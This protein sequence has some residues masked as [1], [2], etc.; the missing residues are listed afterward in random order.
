MD[1]D[2]FDRLSRLIAAA[3]TR[4]DALRLVVAGAL[5]GLAGHGSFTEAR[6]RGKARRR[7]RRR[8]QVRTEQ[9]QLCTHLCVD[10]SGK[11]I[12]PGANLSGCDFNDEPFPDRLDLR[13]TNLTNACFAQAEL[14]AARFNGAAAGGV[15]FADSDLTGANFRGTNVGGAVF[16][17]ADLTGADFRGSNVTDAQLACATV[18]CNTIKPNGKSAA[19]CAS[20]LTCCGGPCVDTNTTPRHCGSC[21]H[22]CLPCQTCQNGQCV[23]V[24]NNAVSCNGFALQTEGDTRCTTIP[25]RGVC[26][27]GA[28]SCGFARYNETRNICECDEANTQDCAANPPPDPNQCCRVAKVCTNGETESVCVECD[29]APAA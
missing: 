2:Q 6:K 9:A 8:S 15:C 18:G 27:D 7:Q 10:C 28:C 19:P 16:C 25:N 20:G 23:P 21:G 3:G 24:P 17:G 5:A 22:A 29:E 14:R 4:R 26:I 12:R 11:P 13:S 1:R